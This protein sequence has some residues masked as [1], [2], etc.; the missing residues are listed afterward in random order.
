ML[1]E[2]DSST[3]QKRLGNHYFSI[4]SESDCHK[5][6]GG[7]G[8]GLQHALVVFA[9]HTVTRP[10]VATLLP[11]SRN[12]CLSPLTCRSNVIIPTRRGVVTKR[13]C[14][15]EFNRSAMECW[16]ARATLVIAQSREIIQEEPNTCALVKCGVV[17]DFKSMKR[18]YSVSINSRSLVR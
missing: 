3:E 5:E 11:R 1:E 8:K 18:S 13:G 7:R 6:R 16:V 12:Q 15:I 9:E 14:T 17:Q 4:T 2:A 10:T